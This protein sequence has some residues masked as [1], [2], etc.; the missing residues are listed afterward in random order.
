MAIRTSVQQ[1]LK[2]QKNYF[3]SLLEVRDQFLTVRRNIPALMSKGQM[4][5]FRQAVVDL[6]SLRNLPRTSAIIDP[7]V[8]KLLQLADTVEQ[9]AATKGEAAVLADS[10]LKQVAPNIISV[11]DSLVK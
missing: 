7:T 11:I 4:D 6:S 2:T 3:A 1:C 9:G 5:N 8:A 10:L